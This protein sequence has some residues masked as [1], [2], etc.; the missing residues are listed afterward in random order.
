MRCNMMNIKRRSIWLLLL[1]WFIVP[2][3]VYGD[4]HYQ[5]SSD[6]DDWLLGSRGDDTIDGQAGDDGIKNRCAIENFS[7]FLDY[8]S[9]S[10][11]GQIKYTKIPLQKL[12]IDPITDPEPS[13]VEVKLDSDEIVYPVFPTKKYLK[14]I[15]ATINI[16]LSGKNAKVRLEKPDTDYLVMYFFKHQNCWSLY[17]IENW[18][19]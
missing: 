9:Y 11:N 13:S 14:K 5:Q 3:N 6:G 18:S 2:Y 1:I 7:L 4:A 19:L 17:R 8:F 15:G 12:Y 10:K 16:Y